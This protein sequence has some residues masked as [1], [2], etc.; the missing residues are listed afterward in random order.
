MER[1]KGKALTVTDLEAIRRKA[2]E[3]FTDKLINGRKAVRE[4]VGAAVEFLVENRDQIA[5]YMVIAVAKPGSALVC[6]EDGEPAQG[7]AMSCAD[8]SM[9]E[10]FI[11]L[12]ASQEGREMMT[13][14]GSLTEVLAGMLGE[15]P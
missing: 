5:G 9:V 10:A 15:R 11:G 2:S 12:R 4:H 3:R 14:P 1:E 6:R 13:K 7:L 8:S